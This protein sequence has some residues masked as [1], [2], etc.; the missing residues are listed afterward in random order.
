MIRNNQNETDVTVKM[1]NS[2][3]DTP[4]PLEEGQKI[5]LYPALK[6]VQLQKQQFDDS[7]ISNK[8]VIT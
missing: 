5:F 6:S 3:N 4:T 2:T 8:I 1:R 7:L